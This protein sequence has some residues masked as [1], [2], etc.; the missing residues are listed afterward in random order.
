MPKQDG[1]IVLLRSLIDIFEWKK[2]N[3]PYRK[4]RSYVAEIIFLEL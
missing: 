3:R 1:E 2:K 4:V